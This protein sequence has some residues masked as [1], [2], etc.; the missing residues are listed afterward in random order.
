VSATVFAAG[1]SVAGERIHLSRLSPPDVDLT[2]AALTD[3][4]A[5]EWTLADFSCQV[6]AGRGVLIGD[7]GGQSIG[8]AVVLLD[9]P[10]AGAASVPFLTVV[11]SRRFRGLGGE[12]GLLLERHLR[13]KLGVERV[14]APIP[15]WRGLAVYFWLRLGY[16]PLTA[17]EAPWPLVGLSDQALRGIWMVRELA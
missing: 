1:E 2:A 13:R 5:P 6:E 3:A 12:A 17:V 4:L 15:D 8:A 11:P 16:R 9:R 7:A 14:Y 10:V